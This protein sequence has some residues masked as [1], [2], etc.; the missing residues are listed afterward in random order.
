MEGD[1][2]GIGLADGVADVLNKSRLFLNHPG[3]TKLTEE[4]PSPDN[5]VAKLAPTQ[6]SRGQYRAQGSPVNFNGGT[7]NFNISTSALYETLLLHVGLPAMATPETSR[8]TGSTTEVTEDGDFS[9]TLQDYQRA[10]A[11]SNGWLFDAIDYIEVTTSN[12]L[13]Q[14]YR[15]DGQVMKD[16]ALLLCENYDHRCALL[17]RAGV[18]DWER[19]EDNPDVL[20][21]TIPLIFLNFTPMNGAS[22]W[23]QDGSVLAGPTQ[24]QIKWKP[25]KQWIAAFNPIS[26][27][28]G[29]NFAY[30]RGV[31]ETLN[32]NF[33]FCEISTATINFTNNAFAVKRAMAANPT[34]VLSNPARFYQTQMVTSLSR[35]DIND[36]RANVN[37][38]FQ[39]SFNLNS[40]PTGMLTGIL[41]TF[42]P[43]YR[44]DK[45]VVPGVDPAMTL[46][47]RDYNIYP[48]PY[49]KPIVSGLRLTFGGQDIIRFEDS[50]EMNSFFGLD[51]RGDSFDY[52]IRHAMSCA[53]EYAG[54]D[55]YDIAV[56]PDDTN[57]S[58]YQRVAWFPLMVNIHDCIKRKQIENLASYG[59]AQLQMSF[60]LAFP[61]LPASNRG[62]SIL[63]S[64]EL[65]E[66]FI[67]RTGEDPPYEFS[68]D[69]GFL[70]SRLYGGNDYAFQE[71][72]QNVSRIDVHATFIVSA[73]MEVANGQVD[74]QM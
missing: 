20:T 13:I 38:S 12:S 9:T 50:H 10:K 6:T 74:L 59:G 42:S 71:D 61:A 25:T 69:L 56:K 45:I 16:I 31:I 73:I 64:V 29:G 72:E 26:S 32:T 33:R 67:V 11:S 23:P 70:P 55:F 35:E 17:E 21:A 30:G 3:G 63:R 48:T 60:K 57:K 44:D 27:Y 53:R 65:P 36:M 1:P 8:F 43:V 68:L 66:V 40:C 7:T 52:E 62:G 2:A 19:G 49:I 34:L 46:H 24:I 51:N 15:I 41:L 5:C 47:P 54:T 37:T 14:N 28:D 18:G 39:T 4:Y 22:C 58:S